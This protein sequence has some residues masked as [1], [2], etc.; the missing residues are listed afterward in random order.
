M[1][2]GKGYFLR[3]KLDISAPEQKHG[4][5]PS[6][7]AVRTERLSSVS[8]SV[9][10]PKCSANETKNDKILPPHNS[11]ICAEIHLERGEEETFHIGLLLHV[12]DIDNRLIAR[13]SPQKTW[14]EANKQKQRVKKT[15]TQ[16]KWL[17]NM[18]T[19]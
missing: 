11:S 3:T 1:S 2:W 19:V 8:G 13:L 7:Y 16:V 15:H 18:Y 10:T 5:L 6:G 14:W 4:R 9:Q 17:P 12:S